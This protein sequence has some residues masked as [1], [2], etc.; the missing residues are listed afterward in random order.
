[1]EYEYKHVVLG[2]GGWANLVHSK[3]HRCLLQSEGRA[4]SN[5]LPKKERNTSEHSK[6]TQSL[7]GKQVQIKKV[8]LWIVLF[9]PSDSRNLS[10]ARN[11]GRIMPQGVFVCRESVFKIAHLLSDTTCMGIR[12]ENGRKSKRVHTNQEPSLLVGRVE[13]VDD[14]GG[15]GRSTIRGSSGLYGWGDGGAV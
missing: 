14:G 9:D 5:Q 2:V 10:E 15:A 6:T 8:D 12:R 11:G 7:G 3:F 13:F 4:E 1:M